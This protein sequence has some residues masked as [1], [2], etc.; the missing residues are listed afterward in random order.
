MDKYDIAEDNYI[1][2]PVR[3]LI[4]VEILPKDVVC[5]TC[6]IFTETKGI[7]AMWNIEHTLQSV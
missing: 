4:S 6:A 3:W 5:L 2:Y 1:K 7:Y